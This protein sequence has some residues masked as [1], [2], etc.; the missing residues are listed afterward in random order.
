VHLAFPNE[1]YTRGSEQVCRYNSINIK[2]MSRGNI[3]AHA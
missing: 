1:C 2:R 3:L